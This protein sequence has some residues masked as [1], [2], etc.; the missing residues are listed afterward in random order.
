[1]SVYS[2]YS[3]CNKRGTQYRC[4]QNLDYNLNPFQW[5][6]NNPIN[7]NKQ[8][9]M[10]EGIASYPAAIRELPRYEQEEM[11]SWYQTVPLRHD[12][13]DFGSNGTI[14]EI[15]LNRKG[16]TEKT[17]KHFL[18]TTTKAQMISRTYDPY[19]SQ[20]QLEST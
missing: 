15:Q 7:Q 20:K 6:Q 11:L 10:S 17:Y 3:D 18:L 4:E 5:P 12:P 19:I 9:N 2:Y 16:N 14:Q 8:N 13:Q 1:M